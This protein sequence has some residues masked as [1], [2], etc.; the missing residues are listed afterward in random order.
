M[1]KKNI[2]IVVVIIV[3]ITCFLIIIDRKFQISS[4]GY[5]NL[6]MKNEYVSIVCKY[7]PKEKQIIEDIEDIEKCINYINDL[8]VREYD[9][10]DRILDS[11]TYKQDN[12]L[13][14]RYVMIFNRVI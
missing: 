8:Q 2:V 6:D 3:L 12:Y 10:L 11:K 14:T 4:F 13:G 5:S 1:N 7:G 9:L